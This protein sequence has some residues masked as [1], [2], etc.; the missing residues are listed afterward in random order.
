M[1]IW[2][3]KHWQTSGRLV[4]ELNVCTVPVNRSMGDQEPSCFK[5]AE[6]RPLQSEWYLISSHC[7]APFKIYKRFYWIFLEIPTPPPP[8]PP[9]PPKKKK[10]VWWRSFRIVL[11]YKC[12]VIRS[13]PIAFGTITCMVKVILFWWNII[14]KKKSKYFLLKYWKFSWGVM[15][16]GMFINQLIYFLNGGLDGHIIYLMGKA[17]FS[18]SRLTATINHD[19]A[20]LV[21]RGESA[22]VHVLTYDSL[23]SLH[24]SY[25]SQRRLRLFW[26][27]QNSRSRSAPPP[28]TSRCQ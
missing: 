4:Q 19:L 20:V 23:A 28:I 9:P 10:E 8:H 21:D 26:K 1:G 25:W 6:E 16:F 7:F 3:T 12:V 13:N 14:V 15:I 27:F 2:T 5:N 22:I 18:H 11:S 17:P 24:E